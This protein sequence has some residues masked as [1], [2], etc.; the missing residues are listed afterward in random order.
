MGSK[1]FGA[2][3]EFKEA[4]VTFEKVIND[5]FTLIVLGYRL[6]VLNR[7]EYEVQATEN[8]V[9]RARKIGACRYGQTSARLLFACKFEARV[10]RSCAVAFDMMHN[11]K[12]EPHDGVHYA[13]T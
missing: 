2:Y 1:T 13:T 7:V 11:L 3:D 9:W 6:C 12:P 5:Y 4:F 8:E 10:R